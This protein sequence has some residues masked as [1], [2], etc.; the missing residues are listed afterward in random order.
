MCLTAST[1]TVQS[2]IL[3]VKPSPSLIQGSKVELHPL[4]HAQFASLHPVQTLSPKKV[5]QIKICL[6]FL[7]HCTLEI[8]RDD[9][10]VKANLQSPI[11]TS[12]SWKLMWKW[13]R[14]ALCDKKSRS[15]HDTHWCWGCWKTRNAEE[16][17]GMEPEVIDAQYGHGRQIRIG[18]FVQMLTHQIMYGEPSCVL[19]QLRRRDKHPT[20]STEPHEAY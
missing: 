12:Y 19:Y 14:E 16:R 7:R 4:T 5:H 15:E 18:K 1:V 20:D 9:I 8:F 10:I 11:P 13:W 3:Q 17:N 6:W 2:W